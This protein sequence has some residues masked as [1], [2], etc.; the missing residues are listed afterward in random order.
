MTRPSAL[1]SVSKLV[2]KLRDPSVSNKLRF[3]DASWHMPAA[4]RDPFHE[5]KTCRIPGAGF[6]DIDKVADLSHDVPHML[7]PPKVCSSVSG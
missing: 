4:K 1:L 7:P 6:L 2:S 5:F 3:I